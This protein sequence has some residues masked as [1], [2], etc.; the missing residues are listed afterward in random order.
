MTLMPGVTYEKTVQFTPHGAVVV[1][2]LTAPR[3]GDQN[4]L[5]QLAPVLARGTVLGG[6]RARDADREGRLGAPRPS[7]GINGDLFSA[8]DGHPSGVFMSGG[9]LVH[10]PLSGALVDR[11]R[12]RRRAARRPRQ[13]L[14]HLEGHR[15][16]PAARRH[17]PDAGARAGRALHAGVRRAD[18]ARSRARPRSCCSRSRRPRRTPTSTATVTP[19]PVGGGDADPAGRRRADGDRRER[20]RKLQAEAPV[21]TPVTTRLILQPAWDGRRL[22]RSAAGRCSCGTASRSSARSRTSRTTRSA[23]RDR[24]RR[25]RPARRRAHH[26]RRRRRRPAGLQRRPDELR[27]RADAAAAR[28]GHRVGGRLRAASVTAA[29]DGQLLNRPS[30]P[31]GE[32]AVK[33]ALLVAVLRRLRARSRRCRS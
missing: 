22:R 8:T 24:A 19:R 6:Q 12:H 13:V 15:P 14:R 17:Q 23:Q 31:R 18:A 28:R 16:A 29:F 9:V 25:R 2:V 20:R 32:R 26:P 30:D 10:P 27:A 21:G 1:H 33:E 3:P 7:P 5:Y 11:H 4:G